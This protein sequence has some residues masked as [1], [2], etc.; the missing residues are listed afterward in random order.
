[1]RKVMFA[2]AVVD[3]LTP[4]LNGGKTSAHNETYR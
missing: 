2:S 1:M 4:R 3:K